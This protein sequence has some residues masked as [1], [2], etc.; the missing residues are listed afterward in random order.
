MAHPHW[1]VLDLVVRT[2]RLELRPVDEPTAFALVDLASA[3]VHPPDTMPFAVAWTAE[4]DGV[5]QRHSLQHYWRTRAQV[6]AELWSLEMAVRAEGALV[7]SQGLGAAQFPVRRVATS[8]SWLGQAYQGR[9]LGTEMRAAILHLAF[10]G[11]G[12][13]RCESEAFEDN[14]ASRRVSEALGYRENGDEV[15][16]RQGRR[17]RAVRYVIERAT[18]AARR[19]DDIEITGLKLCLEMLG[20]T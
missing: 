19:R 18:W 17:A 8:G 5:R 13:E 20:L 4:P 6:E 2:P 14:R 10:A 3:G 11:L 12:A 15:R 9:G 16:V 7:G 1:P